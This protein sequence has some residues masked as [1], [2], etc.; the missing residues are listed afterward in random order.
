[1]RGIQWH[2]FT[3]LKQNPDGFKVKDNRK[4]EKR[5][6]Q[7]EFTKYGFTSVNINDGERKQRVM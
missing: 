3:V 4:V 1:M 6:Y 7:E 2:V 5:E